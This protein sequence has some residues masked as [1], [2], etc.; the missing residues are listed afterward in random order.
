MDLLGTHYTTICSRL[1]ILN[2]F[3]W[4]TVSRS[5]TFPLI[6]IYLSDAN[7]LRKGVLGGVTDTAGKTVSG[8]TD[9]AGNAVGG[10]GN[11]LGDTTK[12]LTGTVG[13]TAK[14]AGNTV[15]DTT[16]GVG[17]TAKGATGAGGKQDAQNPLG[18][19]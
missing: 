8:A 6:R 9:T 4:R 18:L 10:V 14:G 15:S 1:L 11:T 5:F 7:S 17:D 19:S 16:S 3:P 12:G 2:L 13:D